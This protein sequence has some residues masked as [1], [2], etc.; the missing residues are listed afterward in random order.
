MR[1]APCAVYHAQANGDAISLQLV[2]LNR[3][4]VGR[5]VAGIAA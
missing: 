2:D 4:E 5:I 1:G 3:R